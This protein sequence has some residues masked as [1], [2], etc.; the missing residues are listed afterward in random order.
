MDSIHI[1]ETNERKREGETMKKVLFILLVAALAVGMLAGCAQSNPPA[2]EDVEE[3][4]ALEPPASADPEEES[5]GIYDGIE[6]LV[7]PIELNIGY[8][9]GGHHGAVCYMIERLGGYEQVGIT[10]NYQIFGNGPIM[11]EATDSWDCGTT[12][13]GGTLT[14]VIS[15]G[16]Y[17]IGAAARDF[18]SLRIFARND[19]DIVTAGKTLAEY[20]NVYGTAETWKDTEVFVPVGSVLHF[21]LSTGIDKFGLGDTDIKMT[22]MDVTSINTALRAGQGE[23]GALWGSFAYASDMAD[24]FT[25][26]LSAEDLDMEIQTVMVANPASYEDPVK[27]EA[28]KKWMELYFA[29]VDWI[30]AS[31]ENFD[32]AAQMFTEI[33]T[34]FGI[35]CTLEENVVVMDNNGYYTLEENYELFN[36]R[37]DDDAMLLVEKINYDPLVFFVG[38]GN[39]KP[40]DEQTFLGGYFKAD[41]IN[42]LYGAQ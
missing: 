3:S 15:R 30:Y 37:T 5:G 36:T 18:N 25:M 34:D 20:P 1:H 4:A 9:T 21:V 31:Q 2:G 28:I 42:E 41:I 19:S 24:D 10:P 33:N 17:V 39:Y 23:V 35:K 13:L 6:P 8:L 29:T 12:G 7:S 27:Y 40:E 38:Q 16:H 26:A 14:G 32:Q 11:V 22:H